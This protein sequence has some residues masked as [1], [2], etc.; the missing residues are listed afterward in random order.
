MTVVH[1]VFGLG[2]SLWTHDCLL[3]THFML[4]PVYFDLTVLYMRAFECCKLN[5][6]LLVG[7]NL[8]DYI[9]HH[10][11]CPITPFWKCWLNTGTSGCLA[12]SMFHD[13]SPPSRHD[14][15]AKHWLVPSL[16]TRALRSIHPHQWWSSTNT[17]W[18]S[19]IT[20]VYWTHDWAEALH[21]FPSNPTLFPLIVIISCCLIPP[22]L[23]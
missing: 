20:P 19:S 6:A 9:H 8:I 12:L 1:W 2:T 21:Q 23:C 17:Q 4:K 15:W 7:D 5:Q 13:D 11:L 10:L 16:L 14:A 3:H 18:A 22:T